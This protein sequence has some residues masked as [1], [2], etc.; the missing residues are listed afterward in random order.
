MNLCNSNPENSS[1]PSQL[2][3]TIAP[4]SDHCSPYRPILSPQDGISFILIHTTAF[5]WCIR[6]EVYLWCVFQKMDSRFPQRPWFMPQSEH[7]VFT[8]FLYI[9]TY[10]K[11]YSTYQWQIWDRQLTSFPPRT[12]RFLSSTYQFMDTIPVR[13]SSSR[14]LGNTYPSGK[15]VNK[16]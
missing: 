14:C 5:I 4:R 16:N 3:S 9:C 10:H 6:F 11:A 12:I 15:D 2:T 13:Y 8:M 1:V 7:M